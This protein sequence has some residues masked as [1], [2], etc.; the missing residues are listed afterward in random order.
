MDQA[1]FPIGGRARRT[2]VGGRGLRDG[3]CHAVDGLVSGSLRAC[4]LRACHLRALTGRALAPILTSRLLGCAIATPFTSPDAKRTKRRPRGAVPH[5]TSRF[6]SSS[7]LPGGQPATGSTSP[8][9]RATHVARNWAF[10]FQGSAPARILTKT[11]HAVQCAAAVTALRSHPIP[12]G[13]AQCRPAFHTRFCVDHVDASV[14]QGYHV[15]TS[16]TRL[17]ETPSTRA[18]C[19]VGRCRSPRSGSAC[20]GA[21][22]GPAGGTRVL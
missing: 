3:T 20:A 9:I 15:R 2:G 22:P 19:R 11:I 18:S 13:R 5:S 1:L 10:G 7:V 4:C 16:T 17:P 6:S 12:P 21:T 14:T 8:A